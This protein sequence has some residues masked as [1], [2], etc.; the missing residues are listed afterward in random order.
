MRSKRLISR[1]QL[2]SYLLCVKQGKAAALPISGESFRT[3]RKKILGTAGDGRRP[4][5]PMAEDGMYLIHVGRDGTLTDTI[6]M[7]RSES[8][9][10]IVGVLG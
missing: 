2:G 10:F 9:A 8:K 5:D 4:S 7:T 6:P 1:L 3:F